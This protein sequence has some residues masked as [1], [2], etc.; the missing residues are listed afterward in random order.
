MLGDIGNFERGR[1]GSGGLDVLRY[2][3]C[4]ADIAGDSQPQARA[5]DLDLG[6]TGLVEQQREFADKGAVVAFEFCGWFVVGLAR[7]DLD[8]E[9]S[10]W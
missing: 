3:R 5:L 4:N 9:L 6:E 7:H 8:P 10:I 2:R 1:R